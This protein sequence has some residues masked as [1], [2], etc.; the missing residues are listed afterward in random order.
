MTSESVKSSELS[1]KISD[2]DG[3]ITHSRSQLT[4]FNEPE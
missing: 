1:V 3:K 4:T 2:K